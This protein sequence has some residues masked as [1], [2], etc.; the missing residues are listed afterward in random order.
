VIR[1]RR[2]ACLQEHARPV[3]DKPLHR[4]RPLARGTEATAEGSEEVG[5][6]HT[7]F[8]VGE[9]TGNSDPIEQRRPV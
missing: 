4:G 2:A 7:S 8:D 9:L 1:L 3:Q 5:G 6:P